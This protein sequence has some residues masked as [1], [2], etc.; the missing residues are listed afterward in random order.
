MS[1]S[2]NAQQSLLPLLLGAATCSTFAVGYWW[3][4]RC[5]KTLSKK[6]EEHRREERTGRIRAEVK[7]RTLSKEK[8]ALALQIKTSIGDEFTNPQAQQHAMVLKCIGTVVSPYTKRM[9]TPR[10]GLLVP[11]SRA[12]IE[13]NLQTEALDGIESYSH[14]WIIFGFHAN[15]NAF[16]KKTKVRP[17]RA[18][19]N[20]K[21]G[22]LAT[23]SPHRPNPIGLSLVTMERLDK[24]QKRLYIS[25][26]DL[27]NGTPVYDIKPCVPWDIPGY[28]SLI[29]ASNDRTAVSHLRVP[30]WVDQKDVIH[31]VQFTPQAGAALQDLLADGRLAPLYTVEN[32]GA[33]AAEA[34]LKEILSQ[35]PRSSHKG[36]KVNQRGTTLSNGAA[37]N[38]Y[39]LVFCQVQVE[40]EV[41]PWGVQVLKVNAVDF[42]DEAFVEG[43]PLISEQNQLNGMTT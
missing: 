11:S 12:F 29:D 36:L 41:L 42:A 21:V 43:I 9:G 38:C 18:T 8:T 7:L 40:F 6:L 23:R 24:K 26:L 14:V 35:D 3:H 28:D 2:K 34:S 10:Q 30:D 19:G 31:N 32:D 39:S 20:Q 25:A 5:M 4:C 13:L 27:V 22:Q 37:T 17:P 33:R 15:T 16:H 1:M